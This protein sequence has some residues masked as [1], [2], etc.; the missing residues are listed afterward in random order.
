MMLAAKYFDLVLGVDIHWELVPMPAP[1]PTPIP[2]PHVGV[3]YDPMGTAIGMVINNLFAAAF[4]EQTGRGIVRV[5]GLPAANVGTEGRAV[6]PHIMLPPGTG[7]APVPGAPMPMVRPGD[8]PEPPTSPTPTND[9]IIV[10]GVDGVTIMG[11]SAARMGVFAASCGEPVRLPISSA[12]L[13]L[14]IGA[15]VLINGPTSIDILAAVFAGIRTRWASR[16]LH[17][18]VSLI[19]WRRLRNFFRRIACFLTGH[20][21]DVASGRVITDNVDFSLAGPLPLAFERVY[22]SSWANRNGPLG[23]GWTHTLNQAVW[24]EADEERVIYQDDE[25]R[26]LT[27]HTHDLPDGRTQPGVEL[28]DPITRLTLVDRGQGRWEVRTHL[29]DR[30]VFEPVGRADGRAMLR[31]IEDRVGHA[32]ELS[33]GSAGFLTSVLDSAGRRTRL[34]NDG[35]GRIVAIER[36]G[37]EGA[38]I[39]YRYDD[40]GDLVRAWH[41]CQGSFGDDSDPSWWY[42][43][44]SATPK[45]DL[46]PGDDRPEPGP[47]DPA[48]ARNERSTHLLIREIDRNMLTFWFEYDGL[49]EDARCVRTWG[50]HGIYDH[51]IGYA[52]GATT[53]RNSLGELAVYKMNLV[54]QVVGMGLE[55]AGQWVSFEYDER[56][57]RP[58]GIVDELG[59]AMRVEHDERG[60]VV[61]ELWPDGA[62]VVHEHNELNCRVRTVDAAGGVWLRDFDEW[63]RLKGVEDPSGRRMRYRY[64]GGLLRTIEMPGG[65]LVELEHDRHANVCLV[66]CG[67]V[68]ERAVH[69]ELGRLV[70]SIDA[71]GN[72]RE[73]TYDDLGNLVSLKEPNGNLLTYEYDFE[74]RVT[75]V[76]DDS[77]RFVA[78]EHDGQ[79][80]CAHQVGERQVR[81]F[82]DTE[83]RLVAIENP[84][85]ERLEYE[86][87]PT[88]RILRETRFDGVTHR[89]SRD[90]VGRVVRVYVQ[91][92][93][94]DDRDRLQTSLAYDA[95]GRITAIDHADE[96]FSRYA[97]RL[98]GALVRHVNQDVTVQLERDVLGRVTRERVQEIRR[99]PDGEILEELGPERWVASAFG[100]DGLR[101]V[102]E[103]SLGFYQCVHRDPFGD[104]VRVEVDR[105]RPWAV[106]FERDILGL[107]AERRLPGG[108]VQ[109]SKFDEMSRP[110]ERVLRG[111][112]GRNLGET[113]WGW[114]WGEDLEWRWVRGLGTTEFEH[115][116]AGAV[117]EERPPRHDGAPSTHRARDLA[118]NVYRTTDRSDGLYR[119]GNQLLAAYGTE[120]A[121]D[122]AGNLA[123][124]RHPDGTSTRL[125]WDLAGT[126][127]EIELADET[128]VRCVYDAMN[129]RIRKDVVTPLEGGEEHVR[130]TRYVWDGYVLLHEETTGEE[131]VTWVMEPDSFAPLGRIQGDRRDVFVSDYLGVPTEC[132][133]EDGRLL[134]RVSVDIY[135]YGRFEEVSEF[136]EPSACPW[137]FPGQYLDEETGL[138]LNG[139]RYYSADEGAFISPDPLGV[140]VGLQLYAYP[141]NPLA[142][143]DP[144]GLD[145]NY[146]LIDGDTISQNG[147]GGE[148]YYSG[149]A[150]DKATPSQVQSRHARTEGADGARFR[151]GHDRFV[152]LTDHGTPR[153]A[154]KG[155]EHMG[156]LSL[157]RDG[158]I[159]RRKVNGN[160]VRG[161]MIHGIN[162]RRFTSA[163]KDEVQLAAR[164]NMEA[165][166]R[167]LR[168]AGVDTIQ[169][170]F[171]RRRCGK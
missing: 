101:M 133:S 30:H 6:V 144:H 134:W 94:D 150:S 46:R 51:V 11:M 48:A 60:N 139:F 37:I 128:K 58:T 161:N 44:Q 131:L 36:P 10:E 77:G 57:L 99:A 154:A 113:R 7:W 145:W 82:H 156:I 8:P 162:L 100:S 108:V 34:R 70:L 55:K 28:H 21:V 153:G 23:Y 64:A 4:G 29:G 93:P 102:V 68:E 3:I 90:A 165:A 61:R 86:R 158:V 42:Q 168:L 152:Q 73:A 92:D 149:R 119:A 126:L 146:A 117:V 15:P 78:V 116:E 26:E 135:G 127:G 115:D 79:V 107:E 74:G 167:V 155:I 125:A 54:G 20:P 85:G 124:K 12:I 5:N 67:E 40:A 38:Y 132:F 129:R 80:V 17:S 118:G 140:A 103:S 142:D 62:V 164:E 97:Y 76:A 159:G 24:V 56:T 49:G 111:A 143:I 53:V 16:W 39:R 157:T 43:Y 105:H 19:P 13:S 151:R 136:A 59:H 120:Y 32:I 2:N 106:E 63:G 87:G 169:G 109:T 18:L 33:Y 69:D 72:V 66:R 114:G 81:F 89:Y 166:L 75:R 160:R 110:V 84:A 104:A 138:S 141:P 14:P 22:F 130:S 1:T 112:N 9:S 41:P 47:F 88:G 52:D 148:V 163:V 91:P 170:L 96:T 71:H 121:Y 98:D 27:F 45:G 83:E 147:T 171:E 122:L 31:R 95:C 65:V 137:R 25:G 50:D 35:A 123:E